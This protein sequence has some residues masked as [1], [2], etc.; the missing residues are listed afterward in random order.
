MKGCCPALAAQEVD[1]LFFSPEPPRSCRTRRWSTSPRPCCQGDRR[2]L[3][4]VHWRSPWFLKRSS[5]NIRFSRMFFQIIPDCEA[6]EYS[7]SIQLF[8]LS[9]TSDFWSLVPTFSHI[10]QLFFINKSTL[11][12]SLFLNQI[13]VSSCQLNH[14]P[15]RG[16]II[17]ALNVTTL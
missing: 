14:F 1:K 17:A 5:W 7:I 4:F 8:Y 12:V 3:T 6:H 10:Y 11:L 2:P 15:R 9:S 13:I 16:K